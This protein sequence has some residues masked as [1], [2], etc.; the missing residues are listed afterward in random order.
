MAKLAEP[1]WAES[2][3][4]PISLSLKLSLELKLFLCD[5]SDEVNNY[6]F[7]A[8]EKENNKTKRKEKRGGK[9]YSTEF[10]FGKDSP[11]MQQLDKT[12]K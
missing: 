11:G 10:S 3:P 1:L 2:P 7:L 9:K 8:R 6:S 12:E 5:W 4:H